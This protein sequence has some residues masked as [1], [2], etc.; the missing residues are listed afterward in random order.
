[1]RRTPVGAVTSMALAFAAI[2]SA[3]CGGGGDATATT[4]GTKGTT[5][6]VF[7]AAANPINVSVSTDAGHAG[8]KIIGP[9]GGT[10]TATGADGS[11]YTL[12]IPAQAIADSTTI[13]LTP[14]TSLTGAP[15]TNGLVA[16]V[17][18]SPEGLVFEQDATLTIVPAKSVAVSNQTFLSYSGTGSDLHLAIPASLDASIQ[19]VVQH[20]SGAALGDGTAADRA[21]IGQRNSTSLED[22]LDQIIAEYLTPAR[23]AALAGTGDGVTDLPGLQAALDD[24]YQLVVKARVN[25][26]GSSCANAVLA[27]QTVLRYNGKR[28][29]LGIGLHPNYDQDI[30]TV[31]DAAASMCSFKAGPATVGQFTMSGVICRL[32]KNFNLTMATP[33]GNLVQKF[34]AASRTSGTE[35]YSGTLNETDV[36]GIGTYKVSGLDRIGTTLDVSDVQCINYGVGSQ[37]GGANVSIPLK[38]QDHGC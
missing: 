23:Q 7:T 2:A 4:G 25:A 20:F 29:V 8:S 6:G 38:R 36:N 3:S 33:Y 30:A 21:S 15:L 18:M 9:E 31:L 10:V 37:C 35:S 22:R 19:I 16:G 14:I 24:Y 27:L 5:T 17:Q 26:A 1:M 28:E 13:T 11:K 34:I 32:D 12:V